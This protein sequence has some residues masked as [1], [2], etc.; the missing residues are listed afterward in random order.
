[1][2]EEK[3]EEK[4]RKKEEKNPEGLVVAV[5]SMCFPFKQNYDCQFLLTSSLCR[6]ARVYSLPLPRGASW[7]CPCTCVE[8]FGSSTSHILLHPI[9]QW[10]LT[11]TVSS[12][13][14]G[15]TEQKSQVGQE[16]RMCADIPVEQLYATPTSPTRTLPISRTLLNFLSSQDLEYF[17]AS[18]TC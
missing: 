4:E 11:L 15:D 2:E 16:M 1:M 18:E 14:K 6:H 3:E 12:S 13:L 17:C 9:C 5:L 8:L 10:G 7:L